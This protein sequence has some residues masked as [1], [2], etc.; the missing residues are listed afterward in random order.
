MSNVVIQVRNLSKRYYV[1]RRRSGYK[2]LRESIMETIAAPIRRVGNLL[3]G[4]IVGAAE[5]NE[6][7]WAIKDVSF[8]IKKGEVIGLIGRNGAGKSTVLKILSRITEPTR[9]WARIKGRVGALLEVGTGFHPELTGRE[10]IY[11]N[12]SV[13]GMRRTE[14]E[15]KFDEIVDF[16]E[17][18]R[19]IDTPV[20]RFSSGM[21]MR[22]A[23]AVAAHLEPEIMLIDEVL[24]VGDIA[25]QKKCISKMEDVGQD[26]RTVIFV[27]HNIPAVTRLCSRTILLD[28]GKILLDGPSA[29]VV[30]AYLNE[31]LGT[32]AE[33]KWPDLEEAPGNEIVRLVSVK[34][35]SDV[36]RTT[37]KIDIREQVGIE[38]EYEVLK[39]GSVLWPHFT[40]HNEEGVWVFVSFDMDMA[41]KRKPRKSG[42][43]VSI[44]WIPGNFLSEG[45]MYIGAFMRSEHP[46]RMHFEVRHVIAFQVIDTIDGDSARADHPGRFPGIVRPKLRWTTPVSPAFPKS[47]SNMVS[48]KNV[49][50]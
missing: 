24:A 8:E 1:S 33:R 49:S 34:I 47:Y 21:A 39:D 29:E 25:F 45:M 12:G 13:L 16:A 36:R 7:L 5:M 40:L 46:K 22:L 42:R 31:G 4:Q 32:T 11:L 35:V 2:S 14:I 17:V 20:K 9:G 10:N 18:E 27:S 44:G 19:F 23:F 48:D 6:H 38:F 3:Q 43:Y 26:G 37:D 28:A 50:Y 30:S 41:W 15:R